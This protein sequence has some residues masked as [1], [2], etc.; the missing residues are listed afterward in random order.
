MDIRQFAYAGIDVYGILAETTGKNVEELKKMDITYEELSKAL[1]KASSEGGKY[2]NGQIKMSDTLN[3][4]ISKLKKTFQDLLGELSSSLMPIIEKFTTK[5]QKVV[6]WFKN[7]DDAQK[8]TITKIG[9]FIVA[10]GPALVILGK[11]I[12]FG[13][14]IA[15]GLSK[16]SA[17][18]AK[19]SASTGGLSG[20]LTALTGPVGIV[21]GII[22]GLTAAFIALWNSSENFRNSIKA[23]G[24]RIVDSYNEHIKPAIDNIVEGL[25]VFWNDWLKPLLSWLW[26]T[27]APILETAFLIAGDIIANVFDDISIVIEMITG[28]FKG[29]IKFIS[30]VFTGDWKKAWE[31]IKDIFGNVFNGLKEL[32]KK[33][34]N[35]IIDKLNLF[36]D[37]INK[38]EIPDW[39]PAIGGK[40][41]NI[42]HIPQL[43]K[44]GIIDKAT[45][46]MIGEGRSAEAV[47]PL[48]RTLTRYMAEALRE[49]GGQRNVVVNFYPQKMSEVELDNACNYI[50]RRFGLAF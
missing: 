33:P 3:G 26:E 32:F 46:A 13:G 27:F 2:Y 38:I 45:L 17:L 19:V 20:V 16:I 50:N 24:E 5:L 18:V 23:I 4:K 41:L 42:A 28:V 34:I 31:G 22:A 8:E 48:D 25:S 49:A 40:G 29:L 7:L 39:V 47:I 44:G 35:W 14:S 11:I 43:A 10:L 37:G 1:I 30:G 6:D 9:M 12:S 15:G 21:I 36:I